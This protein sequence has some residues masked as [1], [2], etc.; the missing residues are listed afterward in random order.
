MDK[1]SDFYL[2]NETMHATLWTKQQ[3]Q[4]KELNFIKIG[5]FHNRAAQMQKT[6][7]HTHLHIIKNY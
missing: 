6:H 1:L 3:Q 4:Q 2:R 7:T 5:E